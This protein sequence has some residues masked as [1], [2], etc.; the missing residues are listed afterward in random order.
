MFTSIY[1]NIL[2]IHVL[3]SLDIL[4]AKIQNP[5]EECNFYNNIL[6]VQTDNFIMFN[7]YVT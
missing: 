1:T 5:S 7:S 3:T 6:E 2:G 4:C